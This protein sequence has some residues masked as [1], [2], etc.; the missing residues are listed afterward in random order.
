VY[1]S[2]TRAPC[3]SI[4]LK[5]HTMARSRNVRTAGNILQR[6]GRALSGGTGT[7]TGTRQ[8]RAPRT[9]TRTPRGRRTP[10]TGKG[11]LRRL[12]G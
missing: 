7:R 10:S 1:A 12:L 3:A 9:R 2:G 11:L 4:D 8:A 6:A 5:E